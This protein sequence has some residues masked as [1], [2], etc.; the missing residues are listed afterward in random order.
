MRLSHPGQAGG[1][2][3][4]AAASLDYSPRRRLDEPSGCLNGTFKG[5]LFFL[6]R[7]GVRSSSS[8]DQVQRLEDRGNRCFKL[9]RWDH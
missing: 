7:G 6:R 9:G 1:Q 4:K 2:L 8:G 5:D 3:G